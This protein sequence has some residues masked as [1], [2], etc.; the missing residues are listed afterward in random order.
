MRFLHL[1]LLFLL[2]APQSSRAQQGSSPKSAQPGQ[3][4]ALFD[5][6]EKGANIPIEIHSDRESRFEGGVAIAEKNVV[7]HYGEVTLYSDYAEYNTETKD[8]VLR[9]NVRIFGHQNQNQYAFVTDRAVYNLGTQQLRMTSFGGQA[10]QK[11]T[12][13]IVGDNLSSADSNEYVVHNGFFTTSDSSKPDFQ[14]RARTMRIYPNDRIILSNATVFVGTTPVLWFPYLYQSLNDQFSFRLSPGYSSTF[15]AYLL[16]AVTFPIEKNVEATAHFD[17][18]T[19]RGPALGLDINYHSGAHNE[20]FGRLQVYG[21]YDTDP[22]IN[23]TSLNRFPISDSRYRVSYESRT[24][25]TDDIS[26]V[27]NI[28]K[29]SDQYF[30]QDFYPGQFTVDPQ[31]DTYLQLQKSGEAY[32]L[33]ALMRP[34]IN[35]FQ[36]T[37]ERLPELS[38]EVV[39]TPLFNGPI[40]Y[41]A[42]TSAAWLHRAFA[43]V[44]E[45]PNL[46]P[47]ANFDENLAAGALNPDYHTF[48][49]DSFH[50]FLFPKTYF[51]WLSVVPRFGLRGT[52]YENT[53]SFTEA[54]TANIAQEGTLIER[55]ARFR[56][57]V[58]AGVEASFKLSRV[59]EGVQSKWLGIDGLRHVI[60]PYADFSWVSS[61]T[62]K[63]S[64]ILPFDRFLPSTRLAPIDFPQFVSTD[65]LDHWTILRLGVRNRLQTRRDN[66]TLNWLDMD[67]YVDVDFDNPFSQNPNSLYSNVFNKLRFSPVPWLSLSIDSQLPIFNKGFTEVNTYIDWTVSPNIELRI[68]HRYLY[69]NPDFADSSDLT[70][71]GYFRLNENWAFSIY[72]DYEAATGVFNEQTY[73]IHRDLSSWTAAFGIDTKNDGAGKQSIEVFVTMTLKDLPRFGLPF[74]ANAG[75]AIGE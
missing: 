67:T 12:I 25:L 10:G 15:G 69:E 74:K 36:E 24:Y 42:S 5:V 35:S 27:V 55:G 22:N 63:A 40:F 61:P 6:G 72:E 1:G 31:P 58:N 16:T 56:F 75:N 73:T 68:G 43:G 8:V 19:A 64:D 9:G 3:P 4:L 28:N 29:F 37:T 52:Y 14:I 13:Q 32:T 2:L 20:T 21:L 47:A 30:L 66:S 53:G 46:S 41:E 49:V 57:A 44:E 23:E 50:Q 48:R 18:R 45:S 11:A 54:T 60:Q 17:L 33:T 71:T 65:S 59:F 62:V 51:G 70:F 26:A 39:R 38:W 34:Q 7:I